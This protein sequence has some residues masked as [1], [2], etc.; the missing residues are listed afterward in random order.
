MM[1]WEKLSAKISKRTDMAA[2]SIQK[3]GR[4]AWNQGTQK[5]L[6]EPNF[7]ELLIDRKAGRLGLRKADKGM[8]N[9]PV[10]QVGSQKTWG[11][12]A[13]GALGLAG[14]SVDAAYRRYAEVDNDVVFI[15]IAELLSDF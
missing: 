13:Q 2:I 8:A 5:A 14:L 9:F 12:S 1:A 4:V 15:D 6:G 10:K 3:S 11:I 7:V